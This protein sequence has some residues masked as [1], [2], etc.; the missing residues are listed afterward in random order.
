MVALGHDDE[1]PGLAV[2]RARRQPARVDRLGPARRV[3]QI[4]AVLGRE[5]DYD[6]L[7]SVTPGSDHYLQSS[8]AMLIQTDLIYSQG[9]PPKASYQFRHALIRDAAYQGLLKS[10][11]RELHARVART[12][13]EQFAAQAAARPELLA[14]HWAEAGELEAAIAAWS[15]AGAAAADA[16]YGAPPHLGRVRRRPEGDRTLGIRFRVRQ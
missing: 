1:V 7:R 15:A 8:L 5:F 10:E 6:L 12:M 2:A 14:R 11:R 3:A 4:A 13:N 9:S 16:G